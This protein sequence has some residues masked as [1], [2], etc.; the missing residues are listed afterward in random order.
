ML[1]LCSTLAKASS[2]KPDAGIQLMGV[3]AASV[4]LF[5]A[6]AVAQAKGTSHATARTDTMTVARMRDSGVFVR[7]FGAAPADPLGWSAGL[8]SVVV[9]MARRSFSVS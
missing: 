3:D 9:A 7:L 5:S 2:V 4:S 6:V 1:P 8:E